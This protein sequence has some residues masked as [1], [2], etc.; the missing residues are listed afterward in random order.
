MSSN[1]ISCSQALVGL[2]FSIGFIVGPCAGA[3][4]AVT[5]DDSFGMW[6]QR[7]AFYALSLSLANVALVAFC[8]PESLPK[9]NGFYH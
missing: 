4:F 7:P 2:A 9:V 3:W 1:K 8:V 5:N 6:G